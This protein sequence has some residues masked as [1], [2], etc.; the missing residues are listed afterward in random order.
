[1]QLIFGMKRAHS[2]CFRTAQSR[3]R[4]VQPLLSCSP[5][6]LC[7]NSAEHVRS[8]SVSKRVTTTNTEAKDYKNQALGRNGVSE[9]ASVI[10][11]RKQIEKISINA[12]IQ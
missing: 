10:S 8:P 9:R 7:K 11:A 5:F 3:G 6:T 2:K 1:M 12:D 4:C